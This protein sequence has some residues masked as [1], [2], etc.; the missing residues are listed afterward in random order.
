MYFQKDFSDK[1]P[2]I[3]RQ[4]VAAEIRSLKWMQNDKQNLLQASEWSIKAGEN[5]T[6]NEIPLTLEQNASLARNDILGLSSAPIIPK[7]DLKQNGPLNR[8][9]EFLQK[10]GKIPS[11]SSWKNVSASFDRKVINEVLANQKKYRLNEF[12]FTFKSVIE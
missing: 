11:S 7:N 8:E 3:M 10:L 6:G 4:I 12:N 9:F 5:L 2:E 1:H